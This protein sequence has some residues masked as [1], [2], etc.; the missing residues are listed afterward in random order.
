MN[1]GALANAVGA[2]T[3]M[4]MGAGRNVATLESVTDILEKGFTTHTTSDSIE[5][6]NQACI[7]ARHI[8]IS[9]V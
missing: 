9:N 6:L 3:A 4:R 7:D 2:A 1:E 5:A 8:I